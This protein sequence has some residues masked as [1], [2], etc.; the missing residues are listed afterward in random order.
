ME[1]IL[2]PL[3]ILRSPL[4]RV[5][6]LCGPGATTFWVLTNVALLLTWSIHGTKARQDRVSVLYMLA[7]VFPAIVA[8]HEAYLAYTYPGDR[9]NL[10]TWKTPSLRA[11]NYAIVMDRNVTR[12][13]LLVQMAIL[14]PLSALRG[15]QRRLNFL[16]AP[17]GPLLLGH[18]AAEMLL[19]R[20]GEVP[21]PMWYDA[22][23][24]AVWMRFWE[25]IMF[26]IGVELI[27]GG[28]LW[29]LFFHVWRRYH[30]SPSGYYWDEY[31]DDV[32]FRLPLAWEDVPPERRGR[33][34]RFRI[35]SLNPHIWGFPLLRA[36][37]GIFF[38]CWMVWR[39]VPTVVADYR[40][41]LQLILGNH[42][43]RA[44]LAAL[45]MSL[46]PI[47]NHSVWDWRQMILLVAGLAALIY[48]AFDIRV[49]RINSGHTA[50]YPDQKKLESGI[51]R[52]C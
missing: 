15:H 12:T 23:G 38:P 2:H 10:I 47:S 39:L 52:D 32:V 5:S 50:A 31:W 36:I 26:V 48:T 3:L 27:I 33:F 4:S 41:N 30:R 49:E 18:Y 6:S 34:L 11:A 9:A 20:A 44:K 22:A 45:W 17:I 1:P 29:H 35:W 13:N 37:D 43:L 25:F 7:V 46:L 16:K 19:P 21:V 42:G 28:L 51:K 8:L 40:A 24:R 14:A